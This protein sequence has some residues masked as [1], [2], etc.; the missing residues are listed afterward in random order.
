M[1]LK[2]QRSGFKSCTQGLDI[3][4]WPKRTSSSSSDHTFATAVFTQPHTLHGSPRGI[5]GG[6]AS[7]EGLYMARRQS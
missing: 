3:Y 4:T 2:S 6:D 1:G 5:P 7:R